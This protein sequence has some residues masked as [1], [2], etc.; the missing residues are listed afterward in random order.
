MPRSIIGKAAK[1][2]IVAATLAIS[3]A[4]TPSRAQKAT[5]EVKFGLLPGLALYLPLWVA[6]DKGFFA[7][8]NVKPTFIN[9]GGGGAQT[10]AALLGGSFDMTDLSLPA[11]AAANEKGQDLRVIAGNHTS[12]S[13]ALQ[14]RSDLPGP[15]ASDGYPAIMHKLRGKRVAAST[16]GS[17]SYIVMKHLLEGA[18]MTFND[19]VLTQVQ[20]GSSASVMMA[21]DQLDAVLQSEPYISMLTDQLKKGRV[22]LDLRTKEGA[23]SVGLDGLIYDIWLAKAPV[24]KEDRI[25]RASR[26]LAKGIKFIQDPST[27]TKYL[28][29]ITRKHLKLDTPDDLLQKQVKSMIPAFRIV[30]TR[31]DVRRSFTVLGIKSIPY[32]EVVAGLAAEE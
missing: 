31:D 11:L 13:Y 16:I 24:A 23:A 10:M 4:A 21:A 7:E 20:S 3:F 32:E 5:D 1:T 26:A 6:E 12:L 27:D 2:L 29:D 22:V 28:A 30:I 25:I 14:V 19:I 15:V 17:N 9:V 8:E 18:G